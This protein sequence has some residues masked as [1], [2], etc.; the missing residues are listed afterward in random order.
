[1]AEI[2]IT[3]CRNQS[4]KD[5]VDYPKDIK[6]VIAAYSV[7]G[8]GFYVT[9]SH[10]CDLKQLPIVSTFCPVAQAQFTTILFYDSYK[11]QSYFPDGKQVTL[12]C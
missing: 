8:A 10:H 1:M 5:H 11:I 4:V 2:H 3:T 9:P 6:M 12:N 7:I